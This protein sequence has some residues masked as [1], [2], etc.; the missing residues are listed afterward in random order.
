MARS[1]ID[2]KIKHIPFPTCDIQDIVYTDLE[3]H[4]YRGRLMKCIVKSFLLML[5]LVL[6]AKSAVLADEHQCKKITA[7]G[8]S[9]YPPYLWK[10]KNN[11]NLSGA[12]SLLINDLSQDLGIEIELIYSGPWG[13]VQEEVAAG[14]VDMIAGAFFTIPRTSYMDYLY[15][16]FQATKTAV[17]YNK[18]KPFVFS[19]WHDLKP[20]QG[21]T[22]I[23]NSFGEAFD[24][25]AK[26]NL[27]ISKV[28]SLQQALQMLSAQRVDYLIYE[29]NPG[30]AYAN[31]SGLQNLTTHPVSVTEENLYLT[32]SKKSK[33]NTPELKEKISDLLKTYQGQN[34]MENY[35]RSALGMWAKFD[36]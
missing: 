19:V 18:K 28:A 7:S 11:T 2:I 36:A 25:F 3:S 8:N 15:P 1:I 14:R 12:I 9:E 27:A 4:I 22:V 35:L 29:E 16:E 31:R 20:Y 33:C 6:G 5:V 24:E 13:R 26:S 21:V 17:W 10:A 34:R 30:Q 32:L 23:N